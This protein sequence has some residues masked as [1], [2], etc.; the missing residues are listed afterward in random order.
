MSFWNP[1]HL[2]QMVGNE[3]TQKL[4]RAILGNKSKAP[5]GYLFEGPSGCG[6]SSFAR[7]FA[8]ELVEELPTIIQPDR[9]NSVINQE[10]LNE[11]KCLV[12][13]QAD[14]L[15]RE[16]SDFIAAK[17]DKPTGPIMVFVA[18]DGGKVEQSI[19]SRTLRIGCQKLNEAEMV[20]L[21]SSVCAAHGLLFNTDALR[22]IAKHSGGSPAQALVQLNAVSLIGEISQENVQTVGTDLSV[23]VS[24]LL[25][26]LSTGQIPWDVV[27]QLANKYPLDSLV[28]SMFTAYAQ[29]FLTDGSLSAGKL[30]NYRRVGEILLKWKSASSAPPTA[31]FILV[32]E[33]AT[34]AE[35]V[36][37]V[38]AKPQTA[39]VK[40]DRILTGAELDRIMDTGD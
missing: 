8:K 9:A 17:M 39:A 40:R 13:E 38:Q 10:D 19:R 33:L 7:L 36:E 5:T 26:S 27:S 28:D 15:T 16:Q 24:D 25:E 32:K 29:S 31:L 34:S 23:A 6:K 21:L 37:I 14:R 35:K 2:N 1:S 30:S 22:S 3:R 4:L 18:Q 20:G 12:W 11:Y